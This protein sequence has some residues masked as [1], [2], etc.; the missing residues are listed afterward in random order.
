M[1]LLD[2]VGKDALPF[3]DAVNEV[4]APKTDEEIENAR[5][6][7]A[8][9][10]QT[11]EHMLAVGHVG[12]RECDLAVEMNL[13]A[14]EL[15]AND[16][17]LMLSGGPHQQ[18]V[19]ASSNRPLERGD[20]I[21]A[22]STPAYDGQFGQICRSASVG[23]PSNVLAEKYALVV[24]AM[25]A[26][27]EIIRPGIKVSDVAGAVDAVLTE[28][29]YEKYNR[30][31]YMNRRG[32]GMGTGSMAPGDIA[33]ENPT[34]PRRGHGVR[35]PSQSVSAGDRLSAVR[36]AGARNRDGLRI[37]QQEMGR[38][39]R[40]RGLNPCR[41]LESTLLTGPYD[42]DERVL[43]RSE[44]E[45]RL[46][47]VRAAMAQAGASALAVHGHPGNYGALAYLTDFTAKLGATLALVPREG[48]LRILAPGTPKMMDIAKRLTWVE[49]VRPLGN[50]PKNVAEFVG[51]GNALA[52]WGFG[53]LPQALYTGIARAMAPRALLSLDQALDAM[54]RRK[55]P[56]ELESDPRCGALPCDGSGHLCRAGARGRRRAQ[57]RAG[58][59]TRRHR[60]G[61]AG[62][63]R[64]G[65]PF[66]RRCAA[67]ARCGE[68]RARARSRQCRY[69]RAEPWLLGVG[70][71]D[72]R[73]PTRRGAGA[74][75]GSARGR[76]RRSREAGRICR[77]ALLRTRSASRSRRD[78]AP[79]SKPAR[80]MP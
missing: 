80:F 21:I 3:D 53:T 79:L 18:G 62:C 10:E 31:P 24:R 42:W 23:T 54:R 61:R 6:A 68:R 52:T 16:N 57:R 59:R 11:H 66:A 65:E 15:G 71:R 33:I 37:A 44:Y 64:H 46:E 27:I 43:P 14:R 73:A 48:P 32:H 63:A 38:A 47:R 74:G 5:K 50:V 76:S 8:I 7:V 1:R 41:L 9:A 26:G 55:S 40:D 70:H 58:G 30:P 4:T 28:A 69:R 17:F 12:M 77:L 2:I 39:R 34:D 29:G 22:E 78:R 72:R 35:R 75:T 20:V 13:F 19:G 51:D 49:D 36:R 60:C 67:A 56:R 45:G 25:T